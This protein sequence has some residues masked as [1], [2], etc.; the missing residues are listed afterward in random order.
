MQK[1]KV[2]TFVACMLIAKSVLCW[3][4][5]NPYA[6]IADSKKIY[7]SSFTE[8]PKTLD[9]AEAYSASSYMFMEQIYEPL[10]EYDYYKRP[11]ALI[12]LSAASMPE[13]HYF[14]QNN[15]PLS[16]D[17]PNIAYSV[18]VIH[19]K[20]GMLYQPHPAF[21]QDAQHHYR[22]INN[23]EDTSKQ[24]ELKDFKFTDSREVKAADYIYEIKRL[25]DPAVSSPI[26]GLMSDHI[27]G[28]QE[29]AKQLPKG[30]A[31]IDLRDYE[32]EGLK[33]IDPYTFQITIKGVYPQFIFWLAMPFFVP[34]PWEADQFYAQP[35]RQEKNLT[36]DWYP[37]GSG[38]FILSENNPNKRMVL[39]KNP[40]YREVFFPESTERQ[41]IDAGYA[42]AVGRKI[43]LIEKAIFTLE[44][45]SIPRWNKFLQ[46][47]YDLSGISSESFSQA[48]QFTQQG[49]AV[50]SPD[51]QAKHIRLRKSKDL[52]IYYLG[53]NMIDPIV[54]GY[55]QKARNLRQAISIAINY[56]EN[57]S[58][59]LSGRGEPA[60]GPLPPGIFGFKEGKEGINPYVYDWNG[61]HRVR[62]NIKEA[63]RLLKE[64]GYP[65]GIDPKTGQALILHYDIPVLGGPDDKAQLEWM[66]K[67][68]SALGID[69]DIRATLSNRFEDKMRTGN[70]QI[71]SWGWLADY[72]DPENFLFMLYG[73][74]GKVL[75]GGENASNYQNEEYDRLFEAMKNR[76]NDPI[77]AQLIDKM[78]EKIRY[79]APWA[80]GITSETF[81]LSQP[82]MAPVKPNTIN[83]GQLKYIDIDTHMRNQL[84][85]AWNQA[86]LWPVFIL[87]IIGALCCLPL[88]LTY[89]QYRKSK[90]PRLSS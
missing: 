85:N 11:Y 38:P 89:I 52:G 47:Y 77:R 56:E 24:Y 40:N 29:F 14:D 2:I 26:Y 54:G 21:A 1:E 72:P 51:M 17:A 41:D 9:P 25:A 32:L 28:F 82:W 62:K 78:L 3:V 79:D 49:E 88:F 55:S 63:R 59:F 73:P 13:L 61:T 27:I 83:L 66:R 37:V 43:P 6:T 31:W 44:K 23:K 90:A 30:Q 5:N 57:I 10:L 19:I 67:Q 8:Q 48:I 69:L 53:F 71:F 15:Q 64:A 7:Y 81:I 4:F 87:I 22:Y 18:Y 35:G 46:G 80:W 42:H 84:R 70:A 68:F 86:L 60:Q 76:P 65:R 39:E 75:Y 33:E 36:L 45:E 20:K 12:P 74:N 50:L 34:I 16:E 58:L